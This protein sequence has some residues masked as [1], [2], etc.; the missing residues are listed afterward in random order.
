MFRV[1]R[2]SLNWRWKVCRSPVYRWCLSNGSWLATK[3]V[4]AVKVKVAQLYRTLWDPT[5]CSPRGSSV[6]G[7]SQARI[8]QWV[9]IPFSRGSFWPRD[10]TSA[11]CMAGRF[12]TIWETREAQGSQGSR[13]RRSPLR[14]KLWD[15]L[16]LRGQKNNEK[17]GKSTKKRQRLTIKPKKESVM[18]MT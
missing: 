13:E 11:S 4:R 9:A 6:H 18:G 12:F 15:I 16:M 17:P 5:D 8:L 1:W 10:Q 2:E 3:G 14:N 7:I